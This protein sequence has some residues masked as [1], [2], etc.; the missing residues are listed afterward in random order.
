MLPPFPRSADPTICLE[1]GTKLNCRP[2]T[3]ISCKWP[4]SRQPIFLSK[5]LTQQRATADPQLRVSNSGREFADPD[6]AVAMRNTFY[7]FKVK[8]RRRNCSLFWL[9]IQSANSVR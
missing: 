7:G 5:F 2:P 8:L 3:N 6:Y 9:P 1:A 4:V